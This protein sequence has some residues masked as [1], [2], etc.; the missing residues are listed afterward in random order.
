MNESFGMVFMMKL[1]LI[2]LFV[3]VAF[4]AVGLSIG[5][6][7]RVKNQII[8]YLE[9]YEGCTVSTEAIGTGETFESGVCEDGIVNDLIN[10]YMDSV[11]YRVGYNANQ[12]YQIS[13]IPASRDSEKN[14]FY[15]HVTVWID[16][17]IPFVSG[18]NA[19]P[20][21]EYGNVRNFTAINGK[22]DLIE[23]W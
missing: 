22:T 3:V 12:R 5:K 6:S 20:D 15:Y 9:Q 17:Y 14:G 10:N 16:W 21:N 4:A 13:K 23:K 18:N 19:N 2:I 11:G 7:F 8:S 1:L